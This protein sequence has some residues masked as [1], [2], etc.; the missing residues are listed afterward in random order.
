MSA[1][2]KAAPRINEVR[3]GS[4]VL[5]HHFYWAVWVDHKC[6]RSVLPADKRQSWQGRV[7]SNDPYVPFWDVGPVEAGLPAIL[8]DVEY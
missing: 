3:Q 6:F 4:V 7:G 5:R 2:K 8:E 1:H